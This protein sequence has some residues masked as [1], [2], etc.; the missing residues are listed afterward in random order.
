MTPADAVSQMAANIATADPGTISRLIAGWP[1]LA[2]LI[3]VKLLSGI[4]RRGTAH[5]PAAVLDIV[6]SGYGPGRGHDAASRHVVPVPSGPASTPARP[7]G[8][9]S[10]TAPGLAPGAAPLLPAAPGARDPLRR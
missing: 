6:P 2:L 7:D 5:C 9:R 1:A 4:L 10:A 3:A 8:R